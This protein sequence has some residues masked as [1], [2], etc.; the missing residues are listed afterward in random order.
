MKL[1]LRSLALATAGW[2]VACTSDSLV[3]V[4]NPPVQVTA[5]CEA[6][7]IT[8]RVCE[9]SS[10]AWFSG[11]R[12]LLDALD[13]N[14]QP[15][16]REVISAT[17]GVFVLAGVP[18]GAQT[19]TLDISGALQ[20]LAVMVAAN[21]TSVVPEDPRCHLL[22]CDVGSVTGR[23]CA[24]E[25]REW[26]AGASVRV[27]AVDCNELSVRSETL[28]AA[29]GSFVLVGVPLGDHLLHVDKGEFHQELAA[30]VAADQTVTLPDDP[31]CVLDE[32][33]FGSVSGRICAPDQQTW[34]NGA[35]VSVDTLD[36]NGLPVH[37]D[38]RSGADG[39]F[40]LT[41]V[42]E[43]AQIIQAEQ[44]LFSQDIP[45]MVVADLITSVPDNQLCVAQHETH[46]AVVT[47]QGD[48]IETL[49]TTLNLEYTEY[50][51]TQAH[52]A[53]S[54]EPFLADLAAMQAYDVIF[55]DCG[56]A[57]TTSGNTID[58]GN[59]AA[60]IR[61]NLHDYVVNGGS[62]YAS[63][64]ALLF[65]VYAE[66]GAFD[67]LM[68]GGDDVANP[69]NTNQLMGYAPQTVMAAIREPELATFLGKSEVSITFPKETGAVSL[70]WG[71]LQD[72]R[73]DVS[74][75]IEAPTALP[76]TSA[77]TSCGSAGTLVTSI[78]LAVQLTLAPTGSRGGHLVYTAFHNIAQE[79]TDVANIL[80]Y[81]VL[82][83]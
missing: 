62:L 12:V 10:R 5:E 43:G 16:H 59:R 79:G 66:P 49:L 45:V 6:G 57:K 24:P 30:T 34:V 2:V 17:D 78:P 32:C 70:H 80:K 56:A 68:N 37:R 35:I 64:W 14:G 29:D 20:D 76:C 1:W 75:L 46:I 81:V 31:R 8:G 27:D 71:L 53:T 9:S 7:D 40:V 44:G 28:T 52:Y 36:C 21:Q 18:V 58:L 42:P 82:H 48:K 38:V 55:I 50:D 67:F 22:V 72:I 73:A 15:V 3:P 33:R 60:R 51:G 4:P 13:C 61:D 26:L 65:A 69:L 63:D 83:L 11:A 54:A 23:V 74:V 41:G 19:L 77:N 47:G 25:Q 39:G